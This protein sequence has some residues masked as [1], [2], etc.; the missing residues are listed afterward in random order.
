MPVQPHASEAP[1]RSSPMPNAQLAHVVGESILSP[2][3]MIW[4]A[5][6]DNPSQM[7]LHRHETTHH[8]SLTGN[9]QGKQCVWLTY[10][11]ESHGCDSHTLPEWQSHA[12]LCHMA[13]YMAVTRTV[14]LVCHLL[15]FS[16]KFHA[17]SYGSQMLPHVTV[18]R[19]PVWLMVMMR[20]DMTPQWGILIDDEVD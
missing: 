20:W 18:T 15:L 6:T 19:Y 3:S 1:C 4:S 14:C 2:C 11:H 8:W 16:H 10:D 7:V 13:G 12:T 9:T 17:S 5:I